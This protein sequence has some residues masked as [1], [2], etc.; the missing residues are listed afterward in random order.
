MYQ[1]HVISDVFDIMRNRFKTLIDFEACLM[2]IMWPT[3]QLY[4]YAS[5]LCSLK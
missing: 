2:D 4:F 1:L 5:C 3:S